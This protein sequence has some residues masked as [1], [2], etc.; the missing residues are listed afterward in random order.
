VDY[1]EYAG[2]NLLNGRHVYSTLAAAFAAY[3]GCTVML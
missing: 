1:L 2:S 3:S